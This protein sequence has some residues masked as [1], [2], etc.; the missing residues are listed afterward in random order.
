MAII[1]KHSVAGFV[2]CALTALRIES[3][4]GSWSVLSLC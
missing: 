2:V 3:V 4:A 1:T